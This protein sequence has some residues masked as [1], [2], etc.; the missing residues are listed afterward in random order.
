MS[1]TVDSRVVEMRFDNQHFENNVKNTISTLDRLK[2]SLKLKDSSKGLESIDKAAK[3]VDMST[4]GTAVET[5]GLKFN[6][7]YSVADQALRNITNSAMNAGK[8]IVSALAIDPIKTGFQEYET[9][10]N[11][12][13][14]I[15]ANTES[16]GSTL[17]DVNNA[18][19]ELNTYAD[20]TIYNFTEMTRNIGTFT[21]AGV[22]LKTSVAAIKGI[23]NLAA[24][25]GS[26]SQQASTAMYQLSQAL[27]SG[28]VKLMDW[29]SVVNAGMGGQVFQDSLKETARVHGVAIDDM[30]KKNGS[31]RETL[32]DGWLTSEILTETLSKFTGDLSEQQLK[33]MGYT[34]EQIK[35]IIKMGQTAN[36]AATKVKTFTQL[37]DTLKEAAQSGWTKSWELL[38]GDFG[39]A[40]DLLTDISNLVGGII[41]DSADRR[42]EVLLGG[43]STGWK[44]LLNEGIH[45]A[46]GFEE[47]VSNVAK[48]H[49]VDIASMINDETSFQDVL[50]Q[51]LKDGSLTSDVLGESISKFTEKVAGMSEAE[52]E[53][54]GYTS[55]QIEKLKELNENV[56]NGSI[57]MEEFANL[58][59]RPSGRELLIESLWNTLN[60]LKSIISPIS[61]AFREIFPAVTGEQLYGLIE[62]LRDFTAKL[63][64]SGEQSE[65]LK[66]TFKG[67]FSVIKI[68]VSVIKSIVSGLISLIGAILPVGDGLLSVT[69]SIGD[70]LSGIAD[71]VGETDILSSVFETLA[72]ILRPVAAG[73]KGVLSGIASGISG[74]GGVVGI[75]QKIADGIG[76]LFGKIADASSNIASGEG[77]QS[78]FGIFNAGVLASVLLGV[79]KFIKTLT[80]IGSNG[81][82]IVD[83]IKNILEGVSGS[84]EAFQSSL[85]A[86]SLKKIAIA[87]GILAASLLV[88]S[89]IDPNKLGVA[90]TSITALFIEMFSAMAIFDRMGK[91]GFKSIGRVSLAMMA[92]STALLILAAATKILSTMSWQEMAVGLISLTVGLG[93]LVGAVNLLP[94][95]KVGKAASAIKKLSTSMLI[96]AV[97]IKI[98]STMSWQEMG[99]G[100][101]TM[102]VGLGAL[103]GAMHLL[104]KDMGG[105]AAGMM[106]IAAAMLI[107]SGALKIMST[108]TW[109]D[110][111]RS[112][113]T[114]AGSLFVIVVAM[115]FMTSALAGAA[116]MLIISAALIVLTGALKIMSTMSWDDIGRSLTVL[117]GSLLI[118]AVGVT[119]MV[120]AIPGAAALLIVAAALLVLTPVLLIL[121][122]MSWGSIVKGLVAIAGAFTVIGV[123]GLLLAPLAPIIILLGA[124]LALMGVGVLAAG[125]GLVLLATGITALAAAVAG[126]VGII[127]GG[128]GALVECFKTIILSI[129]SAM[130]ECIPAITNGLL[131]LLLSVIAGMAQ[132][133]PQIVDGL[134]SFIIGILNACAERL[135]ELIQ[136]GVD[137]VMAYFKGVIDA[138]NGA[139]AGI[140]VEGLKAVGIMAAIMVALAALAALTPFAL[141]GVLG[142]G[143]VV[144]E[145]TV[146]LAAIGAI[147]QMPG[148]QWLVGE[149]GNLLQSIGTAIGQFVG[150]LVGGIAQGMTASLPEIGANL[151]AFMVSLMPFI[152]GLKLID[153]ATIESAKT[154]AE[155]ILV[156]T[157]ASLIDSLTSWITGGTSLV[158][159]GKQIAEFAPYIAEFAKNVA[160]IDAGA[161]TAAANAGKAMAEMADIIPTDFGNNNITKFAEQFK[162]YGESIV[163]FSGTV[164][165]N[166]NVDAITNAVN[167]GKVMAEMAD[168]IPNDIGHNNISNFGKQAKTFGDAISDFSAA[169]DGK[170]SIDAITNAANAGKLIADMANTIPTDFGHNNISDFGV[171]I[172]SFGTSISAFS[173]IASGKTGGLTAI[174]ED[175]KNMCKA[176][177]DL[178]TLDLAKGF[179]EAV[180]KAQA[181]MKTGVN[182]LFKSVKSFVD[183]NKTS[184]YKSFY[185]AG[186]Y[187][188]QG[189]A[190]GIVAKGY[191]AIAAARA[192]ANTISTTM[193]EALKINS[194]SKVFMSFGGSICEGL[195]KGITDNAID[196]VKASKNLGGAVLKATQDYL[197]IHSPSV[198]FNKEVG[199]W[200]VKGIEEG[201]KDCKTAEEKAEKMASNIVNAFKNELDKHDRDM[202]IADNLYKLW[203]T[204]EGKDASDY[205]KDA[206]QIEY[207]EKKLPSLGYQIKLATDKWQTMKDKFGEASKEAEEALIE[208]QGYQIELN[209]TWN[210]IG[211]IKDDS[212]AREADKL[213]EAREEE[214][215]VLE[216][217]ITSRN[218]E[219]DLWDLMYDE[220]A[221]DSKKDEMALKRLNANLKDKEELYLMREEDY[222]KAVEE[223]GLNNKEARE[224]YQAVF[225]ELIEIEQIK[226]DIAQVELDAIERETQILEEKNAA[227][228]DRYSTL[229]NN[230][231][232][233][234]QLWEKINRNATDEE[235]DIAKMASLEKQMAAQAQLMGMSQNAYLEAVEE[236]GDESNEAY[237][238]YSTY[239]QDQLSLANLQSEILDIQEAAAEREQNLIDKQKNAKSE[240]AKYMEKYRKYYLA[241]GMTEED[242]ERD[243]RLVSGYDPSAV[244]KS[245]S[246]YKKS[247]SELTDIGATY[248]NAINSGVKNTAST[249]VT[250]TSSILTSCVDTM[251]DSKADWVEMGSQLVESLIEGIS[252]KTQDAVDTIDNMITSIITAMNADF[253]GQPT[254]RPVLD[255]SNVEIGVTRLNSMLGTSHAIAISNSMA[256]SAK[257]LQNGAGTSTGS[258]VVNYVQNNYSP[259]ALSATEIYRQTNTQLASVKEVLK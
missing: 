245:S 121:G 28:T 56:K 256:S 252:S 96:L 132:Y 35:G 253:D 120:G 182:N 172:L 157:G 199:R 239:L 219:F 198:V 105:K 148:L 40:K 142:M 19:A 67:V 34:D 224:A 27:A 8:R 178:A 57:S 39:E 126:S 139:D 42:N 236:F 45:D 17:Q 188:V 128:A 98:M 222:L 244:I 112:L 52:L 183:S 119:A 137:L 59:V 18:L 32:K 74:L 206:K 43:L 55:A 134:F 177:D 127:I 54:A 203:E 152:A 109:D 162:S 225:D 212:A 31:F 255:L 153:P 10:I 140:L 92:L 205:L 116:A 103:V 169:V 257:K 113:V 133:A 104:P 241:N 246:E 168:S 141:A 49:G 125:A 24:V 60:A 233:E 234:Y 138:L 259:K 201:L 69:G 16:K 238:A 228:E 249:V 79:K 184:L 115:Q 207:L 77:L 151:S 227:L 97:A 36:D 192:L 200:I 220:V 47:M 124:A 186:D 229:A 181:K 204:G 81:S 189:L 215:S 95:G 93:A 195:A 90:L 76:F 131:Q 145:L 23:A 14:T 167:A 15:L 242:L 53:A 179:T 160:G 173:T 150:G 232:L 211:Q 187:A 122:S 156:L 22:D 196:A 243:A 221:T 94:E 30:I 58:I 71:A 247:V 111:A 149:G 164:T 129:V 231:D 78:L 190:L 7:L 230:Y 135:P 64:L 155:I 218:K 33:S 147:A 75:I 68:G 118:L 193:R 89:M 91:N 174:V 106:A 1:K 82:G 80:D 216:D 86:D 107:L 154:L 251:K 110:I 171:Q 209:E 5:V 248:G 44:Q 214:Y 12:V 11:S 65:K 136:A 20:K 85:K 48:E 51:T 108:M 223:H 84:L 191:L 117:A 99:V 254:I 175:V 194:P 180:N 235:K 9:Q 25:S 240:Y 3:K 62:K 66:S 41:G 144:A 102:V 226:D 161:V 158:D 26:T 70:F 258:A 163:D 197:G 176:F 100:L 73:I 101:I 159:F 29:N 2:Q 88:L 210:E 185:Q 114:L 166:V 165:G 170:V 61:E 237:S 123:A 146:M 37:F 208:L 87:I 72:N 202:S 217:A 250:T 50:K 13:Q 130:V 46:A 6:A 83:G 63:Q 213:A 143:L 38:I 21:A 4:L